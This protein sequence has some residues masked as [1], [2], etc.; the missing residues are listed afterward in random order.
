MTIPHRDVPHRPRAIQK[1]SGASTL[2]RLYWML[3]G[4]IVVCLIAAA[5]LREGS[6]SLI[7]LDAA[8]GAAVLSLI[9]SR[10]IDIVRFDG[11]RADGLPATAADL[12]RYTFRVSL[13]ASIAWITIHASARL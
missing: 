7:G 8:Y 4:N 13:I 2:L 11:S 5:I 10:Y 9:V 3:A 12:R 1:T 6:G